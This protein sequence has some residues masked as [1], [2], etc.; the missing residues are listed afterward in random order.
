MSKRIVL[1]SQLGLG[2]NDLAAQVNEMTLEI[3]AAE[4]STTNMASA[5]WEEIL[6]GLKSYSLNVT[7]KKDSAFD[8][9]AYLWGALNTLVA[10]TG[11]AQDASTSS[12]NPLW[13][14]NV[15]VSKVTPISGSP[16]DIHGAQYTFKGS[17]AITRATS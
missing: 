1:S 6:G 2:G 16:G 9:D 13:G 10:W 11:K 17:G 8:L 7:F 14:G 3:S 15:L 5:G 12:T 4:G